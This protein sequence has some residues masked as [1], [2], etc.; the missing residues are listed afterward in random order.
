MLRA[1]RQEGVGARPVL[2]HGFDPLEGKDA[3][4]SRHGWA[5][6]VAFLLTGSL[7]A[8]VVPEPA[9]T[10]ETTL[11]LQKALAR[12]RIHLRNDDPK[13]AVDVLE[14]NLSM[15]NGNPAYLELLRDAYRAL[16]KEYCLKQEK[17]AAQAYLQRL[18]ILDP[19]AGAD[20]TLR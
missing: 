14:Q 17:A 20:A 12:A 11:A 8:D 9:A 2:R 19:A 4:M 16:I 3:G 7:L 15:V 1:P 18:T 13:K 10:L 6:I 5:G